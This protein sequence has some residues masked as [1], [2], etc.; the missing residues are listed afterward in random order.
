MI[1]R[2]IQISDLHITPDEEELFHR[3]DSRD[4]LDRVLKTEEVASCDFMVV[5]GDIAAMEGEPS[6]YSYLKRRLDTLGKPYHILPGNHDDPAMLAETFDLELRH[7]SLN[8]IVE[9]PVP[10]VFMDSSTEKV[11]SEDSEFLKSALDHFQGKTPLIFIHHPLVDCEHPFMDEICFL[12]DRQHLLETLLHSEGEHHIFC[13]H[14]HKSFYSET[15]GLN[16]YVS[17]STA[18]EFASYEDK[19]F[20][21]HRNPG[22]REILWNADNEELR[23]RTIYLG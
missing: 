17:P 9:S 16:F 2:C 13:G 11:E 14:A 18:V 15:N 1:Y 22:F 19:V 23:T 12:K 7:N 21:N 6:V 3:V 4:Q 10:M 8:R 5:T 20:V